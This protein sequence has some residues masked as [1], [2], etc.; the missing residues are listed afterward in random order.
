M[1]EEKTAEEF[2]SYYRI[3]EKY[4][5]D[6]GVEEILAGA[7]SGK[8]MA[9]KQQMAVNGSAEE[10]SVLLS[11]LHAALRKEASACQKQERTAKEL[12]ECLR[13]FTGL[14]RQKKEETYRSWLRQKEQGF[15]VC[16]SRDC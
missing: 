14:C 3:Y 16:K 8:I 5:Q 10:R 15:A 2:S 9:E 11:L 13:Q 6:Y 1:Q 12:S 7:L 4:G